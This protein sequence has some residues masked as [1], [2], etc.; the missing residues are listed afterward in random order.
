MNYVIHPAD[1]LIKKDLDNRYT[2]SLARLNDN[3]LGKKINNLEN[4]LKLSNENKSFV[5][6]NNYFKDFEKSVY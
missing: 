4:I 6:I 5:K 1:I 3:D 2:N